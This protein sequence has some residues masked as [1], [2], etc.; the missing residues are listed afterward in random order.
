MH[1]DSYTYSFALQPS[2]YLPSGSVNMS[3]LSVPLRFWFNSS[4]NDIV[5]PIEA[6]NYQDTN[7]SIPPQGLPEGLLQELPEGLPSFWFSSDSGMIDY[8]KPLNTSVKFK[9][10]EHINS[11]K[12]S[13]VNGNVHAAFELAKLYESKKKYSKM[14]KNYLLCINLIEYDE[15]I[16]LINKCLDNRDVK[17]F[18]QLYDA[19]ADMLCSKG[20]E[21]QICMNGI[22]KYQTVCCN[23]YLHLVCTYSCKTCPF[24][25][26]KV[27]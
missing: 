25:R 12:D 21:C 5:L 10:D 23:Q 2:L 13:I 9:D 17:E 15:L 22:G 3:R 11:L 8:P 27:F 14:L 16:E 20:C 24:C 1:D 18:C 26:T 6:L 19:C 4:T 7:I